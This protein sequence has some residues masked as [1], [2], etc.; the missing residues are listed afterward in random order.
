[1]VDVLSLIRGF[2]LCTSILTALWP[3][4][5]LRSPFRS[6][7]MVELSKMR[8]KRTMMALSCLSM[9]LPG[10]ATIMYLRHSEGT[11]LVPFDLNVLIAV[12]NTAVGFASFASDYAYAEEKSQAQRNALVIDLLVAYTYAG[13]LIVS[14]YMLNLNRLF[15]W[16][17]IACAASKFVVLDLSTPAK[18]PDEWCFLHS[19][20]HFFLGSIGV[21]AMYSFIISPH[22]TWLDRMVASEPVTSK[23]E[24]MARASFYVTTSIFLYATKRKFFTKL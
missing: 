5:V 3:V 14:S 15:L 11:E 20:W 17:L 1:M 13:L 12:L 7:V 4:V 21:W 19:L 2:Y 23:W 9:S 6:F 8:R 18:D 24:T 22:M 10:L 16:T